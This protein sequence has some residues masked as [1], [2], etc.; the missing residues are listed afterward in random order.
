M[1]LLS[2]GES[3]AKLRKSDGRG[4]LLFGLSLRPSDMSGYDVCSRSGVCKED[5]VLEHAGRGNMP[6]VRDARTRKTRRLFEDRANFLADLHDDIRRAVASAKRKNLHC[7]IRLNV[8]SDVPWERLDPTLFDYDATFYDYSKIE[9][10]FGSTLPSNYH[11]TYSYNEKSDPSMVSDVL[12]EGGNV[13][14]VCDTIYN[15]GYKIGDLPQQWQGHKVIDGD[16]HD[17]RLQEFDGTASIIG[18]RGKGGKDLVLKSVAK[19]FIQRTKGG[20]T[21]VYRQETGA[22]YVIQELIQLTV[23]AA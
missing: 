21:D 1:K 10:R 15:P 18:L 19:G 6:S 17:L 14:V 9:T 3:N 11:L 7:A 8:A 4:Y 16:S 23:N 13:A 22:E 2:T 20:V 5:C 12:Q